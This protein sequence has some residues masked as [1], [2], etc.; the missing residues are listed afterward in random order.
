LTAE[1][2]RYLRKARESVASARADLRAKRRN[3]AANRAYYAAFQAAVAALIHWRARTSDSKFEHR[4]VSGEFSNRL[5]KRRKVIDRRFA[6]TL[7]DLF[8]IRLVGDYRATDVSGRQAESSVDRAEEI[9]AEIGAK[10]EAGLIREA[11]SE[12]GTMKATKTREPKQCLE[13]VRDWIAERFPHVTFGV[14]PR[15]E[16]DFTLEAFGVTDDDWDKFQDVYELTTDIL[17]DHDVW[18]VVLPLPPHSEN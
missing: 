9:V 5:I 14:E 18:V 8:A 13:E 10:I 15:G 11:E 2:E 1:A 12:Y 6:R 17:V 7:S 3:S 4:F 16:R